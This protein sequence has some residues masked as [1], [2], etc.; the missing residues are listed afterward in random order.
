MDH[1]GRQERRRRCIGLVAGALA[2]LVQVIAWSWFPAMTASAAETVP[3]CSADGI[4]YH[5]VQVDP[6]APS[7]EQPAGKGGHGCPL[8]PLVS[9]LSVP[10]PD[11]VLVLPAA[12]VRQGSIALP[13]ER[14]AAGWFLSTLQARAPPTAA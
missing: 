9:G 5:V 6:D 7:G 14:I 1:Q 2:F 11:A 10:P 3:I 8:C 4:T 13:G 12:M